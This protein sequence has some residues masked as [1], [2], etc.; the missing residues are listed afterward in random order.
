MSA[1]SAAE[2]D[3]GIIWEP[4]APRP[5]LIQDQSDAYLVLDPH[6]DDPEDSSVVVRWIGC[7]GALLGLPND[8]ARSGHRLWDSG[9]R[10][11]RWAAEVTDSEWIANLER[12]NRIHPRHS[13]ARFSVLR[14]FI[15]LFH[16]STFEVVAKDVESS[17]G[18]VRSVL[19]SLDSRFR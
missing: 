15:L 19:L 8:E 18:S 16:D 12:R 14:H 2:V 17:R 10:D 13:P 1:E 6:L 4:N 3:L 5:L 7:E 11:C 9:L